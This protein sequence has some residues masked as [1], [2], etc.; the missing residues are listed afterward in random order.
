MKIIGY[1][2]SATGEIDVKVDGAEGMTLGQVL[3]ASGVKQAGNTFTVNGRR[4]TEAEVRTAK[5]GNSDRVE[6]TPAPKAGR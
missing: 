5:V 6:V 2:I 1:H 4:L 3:D